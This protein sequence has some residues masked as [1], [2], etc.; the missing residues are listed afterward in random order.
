MTPKRTLRLFDYGSLLS[1]ERDHELLLGA[2]LLGRAKTPPRYH[3]VELDAFPALVRGGRTEV[4]GELYLVELATLAAID[5][6]KQHPA[7]FQRTTIELSGT[8]P[9]E[10]YLMSLE[11]VRGRHRLKHG[12]WRRRF[13][14][15]PSGI[16][17]SPWA[18]W[19]RERRSR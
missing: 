13:A 3:L 8:D 11:Q 16:P 5:V 19:A 7:L 4:E 2:E 14:P 10:A 15:A 17:P 9:A 18:R 1:G 12:D 6:R